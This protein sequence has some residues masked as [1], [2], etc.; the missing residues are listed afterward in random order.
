MGDAAMLQAIVGMLGRISPGC[1]VSALVSHPGYTMERLPGIR[2]EIDRWPWPVLEKP[3]ALSVLFYPFIF[4]GNILTA[5]AYRAFRRRIYFNPEFSGPLSRFI[6]C[7]VVISPGGDFIGP[8]YFFATSFGEILI[9]KILGKKVVICAQTIGPFYGLLRGWLA[10]PVLNMADLIMVREKATKERL[11][12]I[13]VKGVHLTNDLAFALDVEGLDGCVR[14][15]S[16][17]ICPKRVREG[18]AKYVS[19]MREL[20][21]RIRSE[22]GMDVII[23][24][25]DQYDVVFQKEM[26][27]GVER[28]STV[29][30]PQEIARIIARSEFVVSSRMHGIILGIHSATPFFAIGDSQKFHEI[31][32][33]FNDCT[34]GLDELDSEGIGRIISAI[35]SRKSL[36]KSIRDA[37][38][39]VR[40]QS[41]ENERLMGRRFR[42]WGLLG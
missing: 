28:I 36:A 33:A 9:A 12:R 11:E 1:G 7:D 16:V 37:F 17:I 4:A 29:R 20:A 30:P 21:G 32:G 34:I 42:E 15:R 10:A 23:L 38:P 5:A 27:E 31:L 14:E 41:I 40:S 2:A 22:L 6:D 24:P 25:T 8:H 3:G 18:H 13:G 35:R 39:L 19:G 26:A